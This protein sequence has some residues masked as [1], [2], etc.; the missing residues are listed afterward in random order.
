MLRESAYRAAA[1]TD[2]SPA[3]TP[4]G[5]PVDQPDPM[6]PV[7]RIKIDLIRESRRFPVFLEAIAGALD[8]DAFDP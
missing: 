2:E 6:D 3:D 7:E 8:D 5:S 1:G 4:T